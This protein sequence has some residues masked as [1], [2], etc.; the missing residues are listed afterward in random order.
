MYTNRERI[1]DVLACKRGPRGYNLSVMT[2]KV[3]IIVLLSV[4]LLAGCTRKAADPNAPDG[5]IQIK[6]S[7]TIVNAAQLVSEKFME[8]N[9]L[10]MVAITGGGTGVGIASLIS[11][12]CDI[13]TASRD[14]SPKEIEQARARGVEPK[15]II[16]AYDGVA[17]IVNVKNPISKL[18]IEDLHRIYT[19]KATNWKEFGGADE[20]MTVLSREVSSGT[21][22]YFKEHVVHL[23]KK[24]SQEE[25]APE[26]LLLSS[27]QAIVEEVA[28]NEGA[29]GY[30][31]MGYMSDRT[32]SVAVSKGGG[33]Y[34]APDIANVQDKKYPLSRP[35]FFITDS[36]PRLITRKFIE[37]ALGPEGQEQFKTTGFVPLVT[38]AS[39]PNK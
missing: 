18:S 1:A 5:F 24:G 39:E 21:H 22:V 3:H 8:K 13:A 27:S 2:Q 14:M 26:V 37:Y 31:G 35:L 6:G 16:V 9:P 28:V 25:F 4:C 15:E 29:I 10:I 38:N 12:T 11:K 30:L 34:Y 19:G 7:D 17:V 36:H 20:K 32:K 33:E 23:G